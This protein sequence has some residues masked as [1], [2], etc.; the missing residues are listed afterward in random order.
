MKDRLDEFTVA[1][2]M[3]V[4]IVI[5]ASC[6]TAKAADWSDKDKTLLTAAVAVS[7]ID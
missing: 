2:V 7:T 6:D 3:M 1:V 4:L 5:L